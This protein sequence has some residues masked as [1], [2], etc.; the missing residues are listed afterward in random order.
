M[1]AEYW[2]A[3]NAISR[4]LSIPMNSMHDEVTV[5]IAKKKEGKAQYNV[6]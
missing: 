2:M 6:K 5:I 3:E 1:D 4:I